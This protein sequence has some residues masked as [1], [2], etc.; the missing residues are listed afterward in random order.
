M[1][2][3]IGYIEFTEAA[4]LKRVTRVRVVEHSEGAYHLA[5]TVW[6]KSERVLCS[7]RRQVREFRSLDRLVRMLV[8][9]GISEFQCVLINGERK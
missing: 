2:D 7:Q 9:H 8:Q 3:L 5:I 1:Q 6:S 4:A